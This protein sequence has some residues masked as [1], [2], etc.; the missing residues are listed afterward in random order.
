VNIYT[1]YAPRGG[2]GRST[3]L[4]HTAYYLAFNRKR[5][6]ILELDFQSPSFYALLNLRDPAPR[7]GIDWFSPDGTA[8]HIGDVLSECLIEDVVGWKRDCSVS[9]FGSG[10]LLAISACADSDDEE[11][12]QKVDRLAQ[13]SESTKS[14]L[15]RSLIKDLTRQVSLDYLLIDAPTGTSPAFFDEL[16]N[17]N[18]VVCLSLDAA[19]RTSGRSLVDRFEQKPLL[20][21][22]NANPD[23]IDGKQAFES[24][25][26]QARYF[27]PN[28]SFVYVPHLNFL[29]S[30][31]QTGGRL[32]CPSPTSFTFSVSLVNRML[33]YFGED[34]IDKE[35]IA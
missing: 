12:C 1:F 28:P 15:F 3:A 23:G 31:T 29:M 25:K 11:Y 22:P 10:R 6:A 14:A 24:L 33:Q 13:S 19:C 27:A 21:F 17:S 32:P 16:K 5:V 18:P 9:G 4:I 20:C 2:I 34:P 8:C 26:K 30:S 35:A 7:S